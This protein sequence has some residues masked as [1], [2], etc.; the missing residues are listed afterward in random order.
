MN[1][2]LNTSA[3]V[4]F[5]AI[6]SMTLS[7]SKSSKSTDPGETDHTIPYVVSYYPSNLA[8]NVPTASEFRIVFSEP[9]S[10]ASLTDTAVVLDSAVL[11]GNPKRVSGT[12]TLTDS[13]LV[14]T[15]DGP[16]QHRSECRIRV[17]STISDMSG[18]RVKDTVLSR[19]RTA[20][21]TPATTA[22]WATELQLTLEVGAASMF[23]HAIVRTRD[24]AIAI[25]GQ[26]G[27]EP[28]IAKVDTTGSILWIDEFRNYSD[29][30]FFTD[31]DQL[32]NGPYIMP[33][34]RDDAGHFL[35]LVTEGGVPGTGFDK[36]LVQFSGPW[37]NVLTTAEGGYVVSGRSTDQ[38]HARFRLIE[39]DYFGNV[40]WQ[41]SLGADVPNTP[42][43]S[44]Y[45]ENVA[46]DGQ[47]GY[48]LCGYLHFLD[49]VDDE[50]YLI[51]TDDTGATVWEHSF[52]NGRL[53]GVCSDGSGGF[54][55][56]GD[57]RVL[58]ISSTG[59]QLWESPELAGIG[60]AVIAVAGGCV[61]CGGTSATY[62]D[63]GGMILAKFDASGA[64]LWRKELM[65][66]GL[67]DLIQLDDGSLVMA[68]FDVGY[69]AL[70][71]TD[72]NGNL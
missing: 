9:M 59:S 35:T 23:P 51:K 71:K 70:I 21:F 30:A 50:G 61:V 39:T 52:G 49:A 14:F 44:Y 12:V 5:A 60:Q 72:E 55:A 67:V 69:G 6:L 63:P 68:G 17:T 65:S 34:I 11:T 15:P 54:Y 2:R 3:V 47:G 33:L 48:V 10:Q 19:F 66:G 37:L 27:S 45:C 18:N 42:E 1:K 20:P 8:T 4:L 29:R 7:C 13:I 28:C 32:A 62:P 41:R 16:L 46:R 53:Y 36:Q 38:Y 26:S 57:N 43:Y 22:G 58:R 56:T 25:A 31:I 24:N 64:M 40:L